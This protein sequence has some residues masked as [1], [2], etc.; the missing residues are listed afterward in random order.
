[1]TCNLIIEA[2]RVRTFEIGELT[3]LPTSE[4]RMLSVVENSQWSTI[5]LGTVSAV[6]AFLLIK[7]AYSNPLSHTEVCDSFFRVLLSSND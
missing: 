6:L 4:N 1:V 5:A 7:K 2:E 3:L